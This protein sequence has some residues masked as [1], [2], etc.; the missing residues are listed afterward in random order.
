MALS[1]RKIM[2]TYEHLDL[3]LGQALECMDEAAGEIKSLSIF[4][5]KDL[6]KHIGRSIVELWEVRDA[7]YEIRPEVKRDF[8]T[9]Y[10]NDKQRYEDLSNLHRKAI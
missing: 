3:L 6:L 1:F 2:A 9:E 7:I 10:S 5:K 4:N 8:V